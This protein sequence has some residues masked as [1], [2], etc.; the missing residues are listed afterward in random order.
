MRMYAVSQIRAAV[1]E[2]VISGNEK[3]IDAVKSCFSSE[4]EVS[5]QR[6]RE[7]MDKVTE[8]QDANIKNAE[9]RN[10]AAVLREQEVAELRLKERDMFLDLYVEKS[11]AHQGLF[12]KQASESQN[13]M[14]SQ[15]ASQ[16][17]S[18][19]AERDKD[20]DA[21]LQV[22]TLAINCINKP[23][24]PSQD[25]EKKRKREK[26]KEDKE[27]AQREKREIER[28]KLEIELAKLKQQNLL[29]LQEKQVNQTYSHKRPFA[30]YAEN[31]DEAHSP[32]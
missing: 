26:K 27:H 17:E 28:I 32:P 29:L 18:A 1:R 30:E 20:R 22:L 25:L 31:G 4:I 2:E 16:R 13:T 10:A 11:E 8:L 9:T 24:Q 7:A 19:E 14:L 21:N 23:S 15:M 12:L 6:E 5:L 3:L